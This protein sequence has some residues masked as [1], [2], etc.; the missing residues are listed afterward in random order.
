V[1]LTI[2]P[3][4]PASFDT[5]ELTAEQ[6]EFRDQV[7]EFARSL[8]D[9][10]LER[11][12]N[13]TFATDEWRR[14]AE[15]GIQGLPVPEEFGGLGAKPSMIMVALEALGYGCS[16]NGLLFSL[17]AQM[18]ACELPLL[19]FGS[20]AQKRRFLP[21]LCDGSLVAAHGMSEPGSGSDAFSLQTS[22]VREGD[23][24]VLSGSKTFV[25]NG[26]IAD[27]F[28]VFATL[29]RSMGLAGLTAFVIERD[30]PGLAVGQPIHKLGLRT[31]PMSELFLDNCTVQADQVLGQP[32]GGMAVFGSAM[33]W[34]RSMILACT[35]GTMQR[36]LER[37]IT[38][39]RERK[40]FGRS[41]GK[42]QA[43]ANRIVDMKMR[44]ETSR[45][46]L[47]QVGSAMDAGKAKPIDS[48]LA[49]VHVSEAFV[50]SSLDAVQIHGGYGYMTEYEVERHLRDAIGSKIYS[51]TSEIQRNI[52]AGYLGL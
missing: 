1:P 28:V 45:L 24:Y 40:Q 30:T 27:L 7:V 35:L 37:C 51:G 11:D 4:A 16:D 22:A 13:G 38:Y 14:C 3:W 9:D 46:L 12:A 31:S 36:E 25:T 42:N 18:W 17:N 2:A 44:L 19:R 50:Q 29:D 8:D 47:Y 49:K 34:E 33:E 15:F 39:A 20:E 6:K 48:A 21:G 10:V 23:A 5:L 32:G 52:V 26:P 43:V 41:I